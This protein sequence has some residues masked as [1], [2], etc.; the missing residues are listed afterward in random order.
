MPTRRRRHLPRQQ[1]KIRD[2]EGAE[3][4]DNRQTN[5]KTTAAPERTTNTST[6]QMTGTET[7][8]IVE[9]VATESRNN[10]KRRDNSETQLKITVNKEINHNTENNPRVRNNNRTSKDNDWSTSRSNYNQRP[11]LGQGR[12]SNPNQT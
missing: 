12:Y 6:T 7:P 2:V 3:M 8:L 5:G 9:I 1:T 11:F 4:R 10:E